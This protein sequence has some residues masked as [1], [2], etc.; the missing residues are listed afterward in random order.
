MWTDL[1]KEKQSGMARVVA[2]RKWVRTKGWMVS[3]SVGREQG[4]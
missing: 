3:S 4:A 1:E 2:C